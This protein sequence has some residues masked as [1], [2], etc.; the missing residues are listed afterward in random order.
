MSGFTYWWDREAGRPQYLERVLDALR[1]DPSAPS[2]NWYFDVVDAHPYGNPLNS[3]TVPQL[4]RRILRDRGID[5]PIWI[6][7]SNVLTKNDPLVGSGEGPFR[8]TLDEQASYVIESMALARAAGVQRYATYKLRDEHPENGDEYWGLTR[9][10]GTIRPAYIAYQVAAR[11]LQG[12]RS[13]T[14]TWGGSQPPPTQADLDA[15]L[16]SNTNRFQWPWPAA[17][18]VVVLDRGPQRVTVVWN[19]SPDRVQFALPA[20]SGAAAQIVDKNGE[21]AQVVARDGAY[22]LNLEPSR[23]NSDPR[24]PTLYLVGG[25]PLII[26]EELSAASPTF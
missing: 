24:D 1:G 23:N 2:N 8:A 13:A 7:E 10:D 12:A 19:A 22:S 18:N 6:D 14:Y 4:F 5:K 21:I 3:Y 17:V 26:V 20:Q 25:S 15:L 11:Y 16:A 9:N